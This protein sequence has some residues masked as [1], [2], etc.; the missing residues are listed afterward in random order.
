MNTKIGLIVAYDQN[1]L[2][3]NDNSLPWK[4]KEEMAIFKKITTDN[5]V[6]MGRNTYESIGKPLDN[7]LNF[8]I[9]SKKV[10]HDRAY[11][12][13]T[14]EDCINFCNKIN[15]NKKIIVIGGLSVYKY[16]LENNLINYMYISNIK[17]SFTG[18]IFFPSFDES[19]WKKD[20]FFSCD[21]FDTWF[22]T[23]IN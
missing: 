2:I 1:K 16:F 7:R 12:F 6:I 19:C 20:L 4:I 17:D 8:I 14:A 11:T 13:S 22:Y 3:G 10:Q 21:L 9:S 23:L 5:I 18:N 15:L